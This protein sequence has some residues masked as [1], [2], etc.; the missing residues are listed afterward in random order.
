MV[1]WKKSVN[2]TI[3]NLLRDDFL[4][5]EISSYKE[6][7][8]ELYL[9]SLWLPTFHYETSTI[10]RLLMLSRDEKLDDLAILW[11]QLFTSINI[12]LFI[13]Q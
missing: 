11:Q 12:L 9:L 10:K 13:F 3:N 7:L 4:G 8:Y 1:G 6:K 2:E 5:K